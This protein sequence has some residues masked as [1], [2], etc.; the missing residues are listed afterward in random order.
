MARVM[1]DMIFER[2]IVEE[3]VHVDELHLQS[4]PKFT[5][6]YF[7]PFPFSFLFP[8]LFE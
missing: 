6:L 4:I 2:E 8:L 1:I 5:H 3:Q 7:L